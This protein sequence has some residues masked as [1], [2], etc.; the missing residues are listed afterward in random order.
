L[1]QFAGVAKLHQRRL[2]DLRRHIICLHGILVSAPATFRSPSLRRRDKKAGRVRRHGWFGVQRGQR[3]QTTVQR[4]SSACIDCYGIASG[5]EAISEPLALLEPA[6]PAAAGYASCGAN[7]KYCRSQDTLAFQHQ[8]PTQPSNRLETQSFRPE[9]LA[10]KSISL[11][12]PC[13]IYILL[14]LWANFEHGK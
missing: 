4:R 13:A 5:Q 9:F 14:S 1:I 11:F 12:F 3:W 7:L 8:T 10:L 6:D 2:S